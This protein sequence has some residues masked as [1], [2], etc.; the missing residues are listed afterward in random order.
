VQ[1]PE[2]IPEPQEESSPQKTS[3]VIVESA[4]DQPQAFQGLEGDAAFEK[5]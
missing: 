5:V 1:E 3:L 2:E 4:S